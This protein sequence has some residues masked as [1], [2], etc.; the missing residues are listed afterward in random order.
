MDLNLAAE[1]LILN[2]AESVKKKKKRGSGE[3]E[4]NRDLPVSL[5]YWKPFFWDAVQHFLHPTNAILH[6]HIRKS[7]VKGICQTKQT[8]PLIKSPL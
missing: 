5:K 3:G 8:D 4:N 6:H 7:G 1:R 2:I